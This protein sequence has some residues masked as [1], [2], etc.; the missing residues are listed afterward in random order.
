MPMIM[1][2]APTVLSLVCAAVCVLELRR[3]RARQ[4]AAQPIWWQTPPPRP[5]RH[6]LS[7]N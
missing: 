5:R 3:T 1:L 7:R 6:A 2:I 4:R